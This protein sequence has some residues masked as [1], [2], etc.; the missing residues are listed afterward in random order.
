MEPVWFSD[1]CPIKVC[2]NSAKNTDIYTSKENFLPLPDKYIWNKDSFH[3]FAF[4][5][6]D[7][8]IQ[9]KLKEYELRL[10]EDTDAATL[11]L[12]NIIKE[13]ATRCLSKYQNNKPI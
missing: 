1:H 5:L 6:D 7:T 12:T 2:I 9:L 13:V 3:N 10:Y 4:I 8:D 11:D